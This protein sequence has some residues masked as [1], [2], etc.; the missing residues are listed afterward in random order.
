MNISFFVPIKPRGQARARH[1]KA[2]ITYTPSEQRREA[3]KL[4]SLMMAHAPAKPLE[5][6]LSLTLRV[7]VLIPASK[8]KAWRMAAINYMEFPGK[9][10]LDNYV[11]NVLDCM[12]GVFFVDDK[13]IVRLNAIKVYGEV[14]GYDIRLEPM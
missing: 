6:Y 14:H 1:T 3:E 9:P 4:T 13:Q 10:D 2:G 7:V 12:Q 5:G 8:S 11:K